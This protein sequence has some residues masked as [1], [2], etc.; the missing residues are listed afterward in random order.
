[1]CGRYLIACDE[2]IAEIEKILMDISDN[3]SGTDI[4]ACTGEIFP[5]GNAPIL[6][7]QNGRPSISLMTW[8]FP[9]WDG[10][11][12]IINARSETAAEKKM[13]RESLLHR[14]CVILS[15]GF[16]E[17]GKLS[18]RAKEK[19]RFND[20]S[21]P[22]L[23]MAGTYNMFPDS[24]FVVLTCDANE[25]VRDIHDRMPVMLYKDELIRWLTDY[26]FAIGVMKRDNAVLER[27]VALGKG[28][29]I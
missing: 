16:Y 23:Y 20:P 7:L 12:V 25:Y 18:G 27:T 29:E 1:M 9:K 5:S 13:F 28:N 15:T 8:G 3:Y 10:K 4:T 2:G 26:E 24:R 14:R 19:Y 22:M 6:S 21:G 11:G 17:W